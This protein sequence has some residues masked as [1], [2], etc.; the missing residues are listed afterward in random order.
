MTTESDGGKWNFDDN[1]E[2]RSAIEAE[3]EYR[4]E[5]TKA[6]AE[7]KARERT[8]WQRGSAT[9]SSSRTSTT[10][11]RTTGSPAPC[12]TRSARHPTTPW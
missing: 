1:E 10:P 7:A 11:K 8:L 2:R 4:F 3:A 9:R 12:A 6:V 5:E